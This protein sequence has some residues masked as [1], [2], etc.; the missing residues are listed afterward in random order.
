MW[1]SRHAVLSQGHWSEKRMCKQNKKS[2]WP[3]STFTRPKLRNL[4][5]LDSIPTKVFQS[6]SLP[7]IVR[8]LRICGVSKKDSC[9]VRCG[10]R[11]VP[12][13]ST[14]GRRSVF[15]FY[16][17]DGAPPG[18][19]QRKEFLRM[20][21]VNIRM[22]LIPGTGLNLSFK[23]LPTEKLQ[24]AMWLIVSRDE[25]VRPSVRRLRLVYTDTTQR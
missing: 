24:I 17:W 7:R 12:P 13:P 18:V 20:G 8:A 6:H 10:K 9:D 3:N 4:S 2:G 1:S 25:D 22:D 23:Y 15:H 14:I 11:G 5:V 21:R 19:G 16:A